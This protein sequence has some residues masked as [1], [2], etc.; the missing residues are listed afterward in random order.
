MRAPQIL[1]FTDVSSPGFGRYA[2]TYRIATELRN[3]GYSVK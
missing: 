2:G 1:I 3:D